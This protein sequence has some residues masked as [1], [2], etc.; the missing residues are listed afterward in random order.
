MIRK[1]VTVETKILKDRVAR[2]EFGQCKLMLQIY[3]YRIFIKVF[4]VF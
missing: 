1:L 4:V 3:F 2:L